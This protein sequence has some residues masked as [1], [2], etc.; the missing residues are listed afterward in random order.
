MFFLQPEDGIGSLDRSRGLG[1]VYKRQTI[2]ISIPGPGPRPP[3]PGARARQWRCQWTSMETSMDVHGR[4]WRRQRM[5][6]DE[7]GLC[8]TTGK[9]SIKSHLRKACDSILGGG[10]R[11]SDYWFAIP[12]DAGSTHFWFGGHLGFRDIACGRFHRNDGRHCL[13]ADDRSNTSLATAHAR[14]A[15]RRPSDA[16]RHHHTPQQHD[17][18]FAV[19]R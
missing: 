15:S 4:Q 5:T 6:M 18:F 7:N 19:A 11:D 8:L 2:N 9:V 3:G 12:R 1:D 17:L 13:S 10:R 14:I 16:C